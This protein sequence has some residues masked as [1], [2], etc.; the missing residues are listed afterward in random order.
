VL[1]QLGLAG[2]REDIKKFCMDEGRNAAE[3][4]QIARQVIDFYQLGA[5]CLWITFA[6]DHLWWT[7]AAPEVKWLGPSKDRDLGD[8]IRKSIGGWRN[9]DIH[10]K[11]LTIQSLSTKLTRVRNYRRTIC[12]I[13]KEASEYL[14]RR[15]NGVEDP[16]IVA[17]NQASE[18]L[19]TATS[20][21]IQ[22]LHWA[23]FETLIDI[24]FARSGWNRVSAVGGKQ[25]TV[26]LE[27]EQ[28]SIGERIAVQVKS[29]AT[30]KTLEDYVRRIDKVGIYDRLFFACH[31][32]IGELHVPEGS[33]VHLWTGRELAAT[34]VKTG[35]HDWV[36]EKIA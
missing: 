19:I 18:A 8:R 9:D 23:D 3:A 26:D 7:F 12:S 32:P 16:I 14:H 36:L 20:S 21:A 13:E 4:S 34:V 22:S 17:F 35:L 27:L 5:D 31:N 24:V 6:R 29:R 25:K 28:H 10:G 15:I 2:G 30:Q 1:H 11:P 33:D